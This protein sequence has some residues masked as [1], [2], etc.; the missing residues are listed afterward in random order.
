MQQTRSHSSLPLSGLRA[1][2]QPELPTYLPTYL[3]NAEYR[4]DRPRISSLFYPILFR[5]ILFL[6]QRREDFSFHCYCC[7]EFLLEGE[8]IGEALMMTTLQT[9]DSLRGRQDGDQYE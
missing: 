1:P 3:P 4:S 5:S 8:Q 2:Q 7:A 9:I 6:Q